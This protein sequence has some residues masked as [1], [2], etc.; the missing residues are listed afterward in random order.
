MKTKISFSTVQI[1]LF[2]IISSILADYPLFAQRDPVGIVINTSK[3]EKFNEELKSLLSTLFLE[4]GFKLIERTEI[5]ILFSEYEDKKRE[6]YFN[7]KSFKVKL[8]GLRYYCILD[9]FESSGN[10]KVFLFFTDVFQENILFSKSFTFDKKISLAKQFEKYSEDIISALNRTIPLKLYYY[11]DNGDDKI[12][13][14]LEKSN[15]P[16]ASKIF[17]L[18][19]NSVICELKTIKNLSSNMIETEIIGFNKKAHG[20]IADFDFS[21]LNYQTEST[22]NF[23]DKPIL[24]LTNLC[25]NKIALN[26]LI[27]FLNNNFII[28]NNLHK[29]RLKF[30]QRLQ[31]NELYIDGKSYF[32]LKKVAEK[33]DEINFTEIEDVCRYSI[34]R[35]NITILEETYI[36]PTILNHKIEMLK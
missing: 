31:A 14:L 20:K 5:D 34:K 15:L 19:N 13:L 28:S 33:L 26:E 29:E 17:G 9:V 10:F 30:E 21:K 3:D 6:D 1:I 4:H 27:V 35:N 23:H 12:K 24:E 16:L 18:Q 22:T 2:I 25:L 32:E 7:D 36:N 11:S 8:L